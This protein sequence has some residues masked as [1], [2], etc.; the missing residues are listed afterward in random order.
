MEKNKNKVEVNE[1]VKV[2]LK[3]KDKCVLTGASSYRGDMYKY[4][5]VLSLE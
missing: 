3:V 4:K 1:I 2:D 5:S